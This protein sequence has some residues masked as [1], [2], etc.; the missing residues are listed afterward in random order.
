M[1]HS[2]LSIGIV[3]LPNVGKSTLFNALTKCSA[4]AANYPFCT[5]DPNVGIV[6]VPDERLEQL[7][8]V[9]RSAEIIPTVV[10]FVDIAGLV[11]NAHQGE[12]LGNQFLSHI[13]EVDAICE[14]VRAFEDPNVIHVDGKIDPAS[15]I[16]TIKL[17]LIFADLATVDKKLNAIGKEAKTK[18]P[19]KELNKKTELIKKIKTA[20]EGGQLA[21]AL[22]LGPEDKNLIKDLNLLT[23][24][25]F[26]YLLNV[27]E[28]QLKNKKPADLLPNKNAIMICA[29]M[30]SD[31]GELDK[32]EAQEYL[33]E[34]G[35]KK[36]GLDELIAVAYQKL[37]LITF[38]TSGPKETRAWTVAKG[39]KAPQTAGRIHTDF[40]KGFIRAEVIGW[41]D[42]VKCGGEAKAKELGLLRLEGKEY[43]TKDGDVVHFRFAV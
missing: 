24:K 9:S 25:P 22:H 31:L 30:E 10:E 40:E 13:R 18:S 39:A 27:S 4:P 2:V 14:V 32:A 5:I 29:K 41:Q 42:L 7:A 17:E 38:F 8:K 12:G 28:E 33:N 21:N 36:S 20:L 6:K 11:K 43:T 26:I 16:E 1:S 19:D 3:G 35:I 34:L 23:L 15:D 37:N